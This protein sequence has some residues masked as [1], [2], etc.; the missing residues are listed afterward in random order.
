MM[1]YGTLGEV[2]E[3]A[4]SSNGSQTGQE[5]RDVLELHDENEMR[6]M[7]KGRTQG[8]IDYWQWWYIIKSDEPE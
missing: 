6:G 2:G 5:K 1:T 3:R 4:L 8:K 7:D